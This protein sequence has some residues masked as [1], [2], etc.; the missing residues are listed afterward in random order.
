[1]GDSATQY[2][3]HLTSSCRALAATGAAVVFL[4]GGAAEAQE[5]Q[6]GDV[7][8]P[9]VTFLAAAPT[10]DGVLDGHLDHLPQ[11]EFSVVRKEDSDNPSIPA[12]YRL[13]YGTDFLYVYVEAEA[14]RLVFRD[15]AYQNGDG[16][17]LVLGVPRPNDEPTDEFYVLAASAVREQRLEWTRR[18]FWYY[19]VDNIFQRTSDEAKLEFHEG[20]GR[21][22]FELY[23][24]WQDVHPYHPWL[25]DGI[26]FNLRFV[27]GTENGSRNFYQVAT[28]RIG[29]ENEPREYVKLIFE[30]PTVPDGAS[31][32]FLLLDRNNIG[33]GEPL[34][35]RIATV[36]GAT[37]T[38]NVRVLIRTG[39]GTAVASARPQL[40]C[41]PGLSVHEVAVPSEDLP[42]GG[43]RVEW[44]SG[45]NASRGERGLT[46]LPDVDPAGLRDQLSAVRGALSD[47]S[48]ATIE[49]MIQETEEELAAVKPYETAADQRLQF[50]RV[51]KVLEAA[52]AGE[53]VVA[54]RRGFV[55]RAYRSELD[56]TLQPYV[57]WIPEDLDPQRTYP[58]L[59]FL[60]GSASTERNIVGGRSAIP[61]GFIALGPRGR[62][63]SNAWSWDHAQEDVAESMAAVIENYPVDET[64]IVLSGFS[65]GG[66]GVYRTYYETPEKFRAL[67][68]LSGAPNIANR[69][70]ETGDFPDFNEE[71]YLRPFEGVPIFVFH[72]R[73]DRN[74]SFDATAS[75][76]EKLRAVGADVEFHV[77]DDKGHSFPNAETF[78]ALHEWLAVKLGL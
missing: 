21:I 68:V 31:Q 20:S 42:P 24:P 48:H 46:V 53:D 55:R 33:A 57:V 39:E 27:K 40:E 72:G 37:L 50:A 69:W 34:D 28:G 4:S 70:S 22:S 12:S 11:R 1:M 74:V 38:E 44:S 49:F 65:M 45:V 10:I 7:L 60:H 47:G 23:L 61:D 71:R 75:L 76:V 16:F 15:R 58:L 26:G 67:V 77:E 63:P 13:A 62:G 32:T 43:Y 9:A 35:A 66:Y 19:N 56:S 36:A 54:E 17:A 5:L 41:D 64:R 59:V 6:A 18:I 73:Q 29:S 8:E 78:A 30:E 14:E 3:T 52:R 51:L 25:S 2:V